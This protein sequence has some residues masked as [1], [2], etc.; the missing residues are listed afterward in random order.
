MFLFD[1]PCCRHTFLVDQV[2]VG[3]T[4][5]CPQTGS[6]VAIRASRPFT[7]DDWRTWAE[8]NM[9][10]AYVNDRLSVRRRRLLLCA[11]CRQGGALR[12]RGREVLALAEAHADALAGEVGLTWAQTRLLGWSRA[13][14]FGARRRAVFDALSRAVADSPWC[15]SEATTPD[16]KK[17]H[18]AMIREVFGN[19]FRR[20]RV[21]RCWRTWHDGTVL[22][23][24]AAIYDERRFADM[25]VLAD[26][27]EDAGC[28]NAEMLD[29]FRRP[30]VHVRGC[31]V[32]DAL[33]RRE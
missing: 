20:P 1:C 6:R 18:C 22:R 21:D 3:Q 30:G 2:Q 23:L 24:A 31:H 9:L 29:H 10:L 13:S 5:H 19:P 15:H 11:F 27:L 25:P 16:E 26:A 8:P 7:E 33:L 12:G 17:A 14:F 28:T 32:L 4:W